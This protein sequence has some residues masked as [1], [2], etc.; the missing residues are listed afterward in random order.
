MK[1]SAPRWLTQG[2]W[3]RRWNQAREQS[4]GTP[5]EAYY[6]NTLPD[7]DHLVDDIEIIALDFESDGLGTDA[8]L[9]EAGWTGM[10]SRAIDLSTAHRERI[11]ALDPLQEVAVT[12]HRITDSAAAEGRP[13][14]EVLDELTGILSG[15]VLLAHFARIEAGF[16]NAAC[17]RQY[18]TPFVGQYICT[19]ELEERW[20]PAPRTADGLRLGKLR[21][22]YGL[23]Q[24]RAHDGL[25]DAIACGE[26]FLAQ[27][28]RRGSPNL[29]LQDVV[30]GA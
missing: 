30:M 12:V 5:L 29:K 16:L 27:I 7:P 28:A 15:K 20:F 2:L 17:Y 14:R 13:E 8:A 25:T 6:S 10:N 11:A 22:Q 4:A 3:Q 26:L 1:L 23:P 24:Y 18:G 21:A 9:L 19:M